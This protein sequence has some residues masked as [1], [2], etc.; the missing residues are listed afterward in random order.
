MLLFAL[1]FN[2]LLLSQNVNCRNNNYN[3]RFTQTIT[4]QT[5]T[6]SRHLAEIERPKNPHYHNDPELKEIID[7]LN[8]E[9]IKK[10]QK[11]HNPYEQLQDLVEKKAT[12]TRG[13][14]GAEP[15]STIEKELLKKYEEMFGDE[16]HIMLKSGMYTNEGNKSCE[17]SY[18]KKSSSSNKV[19]EN[20]LNNLKEGCIAGVGT[21][22]F[23]S[24]LLGKF[25]IAAGATAAY[26]AAIGSLPVLAP[27]ITSNTIGVNF[28]FLSSLEAAIK[29]VTPE[30]LISL[31]TLTDTAGSVASAGTAIFFPYAMA[32]VALIAVTIIVIILYVW[33]RKRRKKLMES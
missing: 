27:Y 30:T 5:S 22:A 26:Q 33:L 18:K 19:H 6:K 12:K 25:G 13:G 4:Q 29:A 9:A 21:C 1:L 24:A 23:S 28:F 11:T 16:S 7:K 20:Y 32:I 31:L 3:I 17:C 15:M 8:E 2:A 10:Y 14:Y